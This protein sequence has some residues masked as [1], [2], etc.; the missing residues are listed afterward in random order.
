MPWRYGKYKCQ[1]QLKGHEYSEF[2]MDFTSKQGNG[3][4]DIKNSGSDMKLLEGFKSLDEQVLILTHPVMGYYDLNAHEIGTYEIW[5]PKID[6]KEG[7]GNH[8]YFELF[9]KL[10]FLTKAEMNQP[11]S[12]LLD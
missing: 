2:K 12:I 1:F 3:S 10:G 11:H 9:E 5:H 7:T 4:V 6:L 8:I